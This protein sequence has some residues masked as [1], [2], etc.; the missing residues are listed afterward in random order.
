MK[1]QTIAISVLALGVI[2]FSASAQNNMISKF[3]SGTMPSGLTQSSL[4]DD[5]ANVGLGTLIPAAKL[6]VV[7][8]TSA[9][10]VAHFQT[11]SGLTGLVIKDNGKIGI[12]ST[13]SA[14]QLDVRATGLP[15]TYENIFMFTVTDAVVSGTATDYVTITN[16]TNTDG[17]FV[18]LIASCYG[19]GSSSPSLNFRAQTPG[20]NDNGTAPI[21]KFDAY[22]LNPNAL[23]VNRPL[24]Q[25]ANY[26]NTRVNIYPNGSI[27]SGSLPNGSVSATP[28]AQLH[29]VGSGATSATF[30]AKFQNS[31]SADIFAIR[32][33]NKIIYTDGNQGVGKVLTSDANGVASWQTV[34]SGGSSQWTTSGSN[35]YYNTGNVG[36]GTTSPWDKLHINASGGGIIRLTNDNT[37]YLQSQLVTTGNIRNIALQ[38]NSAFNATNQNETSAIK[39]GYYADPGGRVRNAAIRFF[40]Q[41]DGS[42]ATQERM[43]I[44]GGNVGIGTTSP[45]FK[46]DVVG[47][48]AS[49]YTYLDNTIDVDNGYT[50]SNFGSNVYWNPT[51]SMWEVKAIGANDFS[52][53]IHPNNDGIAFITAVSLANAPRSLTHSQ[54]IAFERMRINANGNVLINKT[55]QTN[56]AYK[57]DVNGMIRSNEVVV[58][59]TGADFVFDENYELRKLEAVEKFIKENKH[60]PEIESA[61]EMSNNGVGVGKLNTQLLQKVEEL[62]LYLID[63]DKKVT[64]LQQ[65]NNMLK[66]QLK[67]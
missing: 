62:T 36:M 28:I 56:S 8:G 11:N 25:F 15:N 50:R 32:N 61:E 55:S 35:I 65:E 43:C 49:G 59:T 60:L 12:G 54:F 24:V 4:F 14:S 39:F 20:T 3:N 1:K 27:Y 46:L 52:S 2:S 47:Q 33:D 13:G 38:W 41:D 64:A 7:N 63:L 51:N 45:M 40:T 48:V 23:V 5:G 31:S 66:S 21:S 67:K 58:N 29:I 44:V 16:A 57:L 30:A 9:I 6:H 34:G 53:I 26:G 19:S 17:Q 37:S 42:G 22:L 10:P 18:P